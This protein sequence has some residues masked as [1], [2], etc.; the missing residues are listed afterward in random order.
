MRGLEE[1]E[2]KRKE[3]RRVKGTPKWGPEERRNREKEKELT[4]EIM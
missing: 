3:G 1:M 4:L 2:E